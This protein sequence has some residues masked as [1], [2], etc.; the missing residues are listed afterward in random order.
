MN[1][2]LG[3]HKIKIDLHVLRMRDFDIILGIDWLR[4]NKAV[5][6]CSDI[7]I[8]FET[9]D[10]QH[11]TFNGTKDRTGVRVIS[12]IKAAKLLQKGT[13]QRYLVSISATT[14]DTNS[15]AEVR[16]VRE[17]PDVFPDE[18][19]GLP[20]DRQIE[21]TINLTPGVTLVSKSQ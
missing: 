10:S 4:K 5:I 11:I 2:K 6:K 17:Y 7:E 20:P 19:S 3:E 13:S 9:L 12:A 21:F 15:L 14:K 18:L 1:I 8:D 16:I